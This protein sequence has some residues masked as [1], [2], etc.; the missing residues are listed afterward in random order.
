MRRAPQMK[1]EALGHH[2]RD[3]PTAGAGGRAMGSAPLR[4]AAP[5]REGYGDGGPAMDGGE[6]GGQAGHTG[7]FGSRAAAAGAGMRGGGAGGA[8]ADFELPLDL[9][10]DPNG[11][12]SD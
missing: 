1:Q 11:R 12:T 9:F 10:V 7:L 2:Y 8:A 5:E 3:G 4:P 6:Q